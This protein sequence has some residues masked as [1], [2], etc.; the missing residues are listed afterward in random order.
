[1]LS[2]RIRFLPAALALMLAS[3][4]ELF[5]A[6]SSRREGCVPVGG[7]I[8][9]GSGEQR[10]DALVSLARRA[11]LLLGESH[12]EAE[13]HRWQLHA[14]AALISHRPAMVLGFEMFPRRVQPVL[15][16]WSNGELDEAAFLREVDWPE[17]WGMDAGLYL[18]LFHF[19]RMHRLPMLA[20]NVDRATRRRVAAQGLGTIAIAEREGVGD[21]V[22]AASSYRDRLFE[23]FKKHPLGG[24]GARVDSEQ[25]QRFV[26]A[27]LFP[28]APWPRQSLARGAKGAWWSASSARV[29]WSIALAWRTSSP[30]SVFTTSPRRSPGM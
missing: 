17:I 19:A 24:E 21:P 27:Q 4:V 11:V 18:P 20:L 8:H 1:M 16:R 13:H 29:M 10:D 12:E 9:P 30:P 26:E 2:A 23:V 5:G 6:D 28:T 3:P 15:D 22:P 7:W 25:F 14:V